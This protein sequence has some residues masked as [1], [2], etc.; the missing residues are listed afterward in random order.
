M[1][2]LN[3]TDYPLKLPPPQVPNYHFI[4]Q[5][6]VLPNIF[7]SSLPYPILP[8]VQPRGMYMPDL[9]LFH[10]TNPEFSGARIHKWTQDE[11]NLLT[12]SVDK[13]GTKAWS[14]VSRLINSALHHE[15]PIRQGKHCRERWHNHLNPDL[16]S[17]YNVETEWTLE[18]DILLLKLHMELGNSW[19]RISLNLEGRTENS[20]KNRWNSIMR[21][22]RINLKYLKT[23]MKEDEILVYS[24]LLNG[25]RSLE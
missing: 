12:E 23:G 22:H 20:V 16:K 11:D 24:K 15:K 6:P 5:V 1:E 7:A 9:D 19:S 17:K 2:S 18:E 14:Q 13:F 10:S 3:R 21:K 4:P 25:L 8:M